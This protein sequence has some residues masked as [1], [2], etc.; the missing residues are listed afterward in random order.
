LSSLLT[1]LTA[2][3]ASSYAAIKSEES[4]RVG[5]FGSISSSLTT[6]QATSGSNTASIQQEALTRANETG[7]LFA[8][9][10]V[11]V[12]VAG[13]V[14]GFGLASTLNG[15]TPISSFGVRATNF[16]IAAPSVSSATAPTSNLYTG[17]VWRDTSVTPNVT[18]YYTGSVWSLTPQNLPFIVQTSPTTINGV[19]V[20]AG[21]YIDTAFIRDGTITT[22]KIGNAAIDNAKIAN[23]DAAKITAGTIAADRLDATIIT[24]KVLTVDWAKIT[25]ASVTNAQI[26]NLDAGKITTGFLSANRIAANTI[27]ATQ[28]DSRNLT[29]KDSAGNIVF[30]SGDAQTLLNGNPANLVADDGFYDPTRLFSYGTTR[31]TDWPAGFIPANGGAGQP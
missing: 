19:A 3:D 6:L 16:F 25:N 30:A 12:D 15:A 4:A 17:Y 10:T 11:K 9:Y 5:N 24:G 7:S 20:P 1:G 23:L 27:T 29:I 31:L 13:H 18:R 21:V 14:S 26:A 22:A 28:I 2:A 8:Q